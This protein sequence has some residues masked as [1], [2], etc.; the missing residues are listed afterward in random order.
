VRECPRCFRCWNDGVDVCSY[1][2]APLQSA[3]PGPPIIDGKY[4]VDRRLGHGGMGVVY[5]VHHLR[6][7]KTFALKVIATFDRRFFDRFRAEA[8]TLGTLKHPNIVDVTDFGIDPR[9]GGLP[10]LVMEYLEGGTLADRCRRDGPLALE[11]GLPIFEAIASAIDHAH[12][13]GV[14]HLDLKP[15]NVFLAAGSAHQTI[16]ILDFG[17]ARFVSDRPS[18]DESVASCED[19]DGAAD[20]ESFPLPVQRDDDR[21]AAR[22]LELGLGGTSGRERDDAPIASGLLDDEEQFITLSQ[23]SERRCFGTIPYMAP[24]ILRGQTATHASDIYAFAVLMYEVLVGRR[25]FQGTVSE[26]VAGH[27]TAAPPPPSTVNAAVPSECDSALLRALQQLPRDRPQRAADVVRQVRMGAL[28]AQSRAWRVKEVPRRVAL[29]AVATVSLL[30]GLSP[31]WRLGA[32]QQLENRSVDA[33]FL[34]LPK[35][36]PDPRLILVSLD[37]ASLD[38]DPTPL[39]QKA[40]DVGRELARVFAAGARGIAIDFLLPETWSQSRVFSD[41]ILKH[42]DGLTLAAFSSPSGDVIGPE[43]LNDL[44][45]AA[46]GPERA[47]SL[48]AFVNLD[49]D[50]D[51]V[52]RRVRLRYL[53]QSGHERDAWAAHAVKTF[54][55]RSAN[56]SSPDREMSR[57]ANPRVWIDYSVEWQRFKR[58]SWKDLATTLELEPYIFRGQLVFVGGDFIG[59]GG[60]YHRVP[61]GTATEGVSGLVLQALIANTILSRFP[62]RDVPT[63]TFT[64]LVG[65]GV[66]VAVLMSSILLITR[67]LTLV[68]FAFAVI[69]AYLGFVI[70]VFV[71]AQLLLPVTAPLATAAVAILFGIVLR[72]ALPAFPESTLEEA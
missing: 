42:S 37:E 58:V 71:R 39:P 4:R 33:R 22:L 68:L 55:S 60:D 45:A 70:V 2:Q 38:A 1:D 36:A 30:L 6:L 56:G 21:H 43:C 57:E 41:L 26:I 7:Q 32:F 20:G 50:P 69:A 11:Q 54:W 46:L 65:T 24:E 15:A 49:E 48:F 72:Q 5:R 67:R 27:T 34:T 31:L 16:K 14:L 47:S 53:D 64:Y 61:S 51:G 35:R 52:N 29:A 59:F 3:F 17:L 44:T 40:D 23:I 12:E 10:Y 18:R 19:N 13:R 25:P 63:T 9:S 66:V 8:E 62:V 28:R